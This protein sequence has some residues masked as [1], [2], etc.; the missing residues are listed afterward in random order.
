MPTETVE[1]VKGRFKKFLSTLKDAI[2]FHSAAQNIFWSLLLLALALT[3]TFFIVRAIGV[4]IVIGNLA[5]LLYDW[6]QYRKEKKE[7]A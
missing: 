4:A 5:V 1:D 6:Y 2:Y 3:N 7:D